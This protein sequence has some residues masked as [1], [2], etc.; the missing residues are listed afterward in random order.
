M[1]TGLTAIQVQAQ[2]RLH[3]RR[4]RERGG[5]GTAWAPQAGPQLDAYLSDADVLGY[6]GAAG[7]GK[8]DLVLGLAG[9][10][11]YR[12]IVFR[13]VFPSLR[14]NIERSKEI[15][16]EVGAYNESAH[17][18][19]LS[20]GRMIE[21]GSVQYD[22]D[23]KKFQ[24]Q[25]HDFIAFD[26]ATEF[27]EQTVRFLIGWN[28]TT[29]HGQRCRV[30]LP[31]NPP[32][33]D[34]GSWVITFFAPWLDP[35]HPNPAQDRE[36][37]YYAMIDGEE[38]EYT[39]PVDIPND[40]LYKSRTFIHAS[41]KDNPILEA[42]GYGAT[43][44][45]MPEPLRSLLR[46]NFSAGRVAD[47]YQV[48]PAAWVRAAQARWS[49]TQPD[50]ALLSVG[51]DVARGGKDKTVLARLYGSWV[52]P[53]DKRPGIQT[54]DGPSAASL[55]LPY[56]SAVRGISVDVIGVGASAYDTLKGNG[57]RAYGVNFAEGAPEL[58]DKSGRLKFR[59]VR[60][61]AYW[62]L[63]EALDPDHGDGL[64]LPPDPELLADLCAP[65][66][67]LTTG[68]ILIE[69]KEDIIE[70]L[71]RSPDCGDALALAYYGAGYGK[72]NSAVGAFL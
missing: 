48:I 25:P 47:P 4:Q 60:A 59:N 54:P 53:L 64:A 44:D 72:S 69:S 36:L 12:S 51:L 33:D 2:A 15:Y 1:T 46:G 65:K 9:T 62:K 58:R 68:G 6:G 8:T 70:R 31:F 61:A 28:R 13:R 43:I 29:R 19:R 45:A 52:A 38:R 71:G 41:L 18:W 42:T 3:L 20:D 40:V 34:A 30:V 63:R 55:A 37:R 32:L 27:S 56:A 66:W 23:K 22:E 10:R 24:G 14:G 50:D 67:S 21:F 5:M 35:E 39:D 57:I 16:N 17:I 49:S 26:E 7:G 11:H